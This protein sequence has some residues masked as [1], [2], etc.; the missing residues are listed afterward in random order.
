MLSFSFLSSALLKPVSWYYH[1]SLARLEP[2]WV[3]E[4]EHSH[5]FWASNWEKT[6]F[7]FLSLSNIPYLESRRFFEG[8][9]A[10]VH[11]GTWNLVRI[12]FAWF[13]LWLQLVHYG[14][15]VT[16]FVCKK[17]VLFVDKP[18]KC[19]HFPSKMYKTD[20]SSPISNNRS[21]VPMHRLMTSNN[22][23]YIRKGTIWLQ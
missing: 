10:K 22:I 21:L 5:S 7:L 13:W 14:R 18:K 17:G 4:L 15:Q 16:I 12:V 11:F 6:F 3:W 8:S 23:R 19:C 1:F 2:S 9:V 20:K